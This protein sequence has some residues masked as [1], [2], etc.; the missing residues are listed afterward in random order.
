[1][2]IKDVT[3]E[4]ALLLGVCLSSFLIGACN[5]GFSDPFVAP[6]IG[7]KFYIPSYPDGQ[8]TMSLTSESV[9]TRATLIKLATSSEILNSRRVHSS[10]GAETPIGFKSITLLGKYDSKEVYDQL[11]IKKLNDNDECRATANDIRELLMSYPSMTLVCGLDFTNAFREALSVTVVTDDGKEHSFT[12]W[13]S[14]FS[15]GAGYRVVIQSL[16]L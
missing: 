5:Q 4:K 13:A 7:Q 15:D 6:P 8:T 16:S 3:A 9:K 14:H 1:M 11:R 2:D 12:S 10:V